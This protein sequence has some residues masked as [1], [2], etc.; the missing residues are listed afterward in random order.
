MGATLSAFIPSYTKPPITS[1]FS[2]WSS[3]VKPLRHNLT[4]P[5]IGELFLPCSGLQSLVRQIKE[6]FCESFN[7]HLRHF[8]HSLSWPCIVNCDT[9]DDGCFD[10]LHR[11]PS[12][13]SKTAVTVPHL[14][15]AWCQSRAAS[16]SPQTPTRTADSRRIGGRGGMLQVRHCR[17]DGRQ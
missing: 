11:T 4:Q 8:L 16:F 10:Y 12:P 1:N 17:V 3:L 9:C 2:V 14:V 13:P 6:R 15:A 5:L 7:A